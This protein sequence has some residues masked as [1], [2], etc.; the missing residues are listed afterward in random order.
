MFVLMEAL[1]FVSCYA[2]QIGSR[3]S[4][5]VTTIVV[6]FFLPEIVMLFGNNQYDLVYRY[7]VPGN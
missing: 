7:F 5:L 1:P 6:Y 4:S 3:K 2:P